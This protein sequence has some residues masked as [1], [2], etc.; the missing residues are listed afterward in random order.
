MGQSGSK[1][2]EGAHQRPVV[3]TG[4]LW[5]AA[6][7]WVR[8]GRVLL[9]QRRSH[10]LWVPPGGHVEPAE[11]FAQAAVREF[12]EETGVKVRVLSNA[13]VIHPPDHNATPEPVP[14]YVDLEREG[15]SKPALVQFFFVDADAD[16]EAVS[17]MDPEVARCKWFVAAQLATIATYA[18]VKSLARYALSSYPQAQ[19]DLPDGLTAI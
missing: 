17:P 4:L 6:G 18:Q 19:G 3:D 5:V 12:L 10:R 16:P 13:P 7:Y 2:S 1:Q 15:F 9:V 8:D 14:F 11:T